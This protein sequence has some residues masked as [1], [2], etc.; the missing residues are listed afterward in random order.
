MGKISNALLIRAHRLR[1][2]NTVGGTPHHCLANDARWLFTP[3]LT[4]LSRVHC[5]V[6]AHCWK[7][8]WRRRKFLRNSRRR[9]LSPMQKSRRPPRTQQ[10]CTPQRGIAGARLGTRPSALIHC[11]PKG[12][13]TQCIQASLQRW[14][15]I[16]DKAAKLQRSVTT[17]TIFTA[18]RRPI[19]NISI[20]GTGKKNAGPM[21]RFGSAVIAKQLSESADRHSACSSWLFS[22]LLTT[23]LGTP[24]VRQCRAS[25]PYHGFSGFPMMPTML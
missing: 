10:R 2:S 19:C 8:R 5:E 24:R 13:A 3:I 1:P 16:R 17:E 22:Q 25:V 18:S 15:V 9:A 20:F 21:L 11:R 23:T 6:P 7:P 4:C 12:C 14:R